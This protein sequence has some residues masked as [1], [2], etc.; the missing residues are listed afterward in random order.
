MHNIF[1]FQDNDSL[2]SWINYLENL[3]TKT[4]NLNLDNVYLVANR[5]QL[6]NPAKFVFIVTGTNGKGTTC[7]VLEKLLINAGYSVGVYNSPH[8]INYTER[9]RIQGQEL[10]DAQHVNSFLNIELNRKNTLLTYFEFST[11]SALHLFK[12]IKLD[13]VILEVGLGG[14]LDA[15]NIIDADI[16]IITNIDLDHTN[17]LGNTRESI[18]REKAGVFRTNKLAIVAEQNMP[19]SISTIAKQKNTKLLKIHQEW[20][21]KT[22]NLNWS[23]YDSYGKLENL[24]LLNIPLVNAASALVALRSA[25]FKISELNIRQNLP[26]ISIP[27]RFQIINQHP[28]IILD[29]AHNPHA[30]NYLAAR[31]ISLRKIGKIHAIVGMLKDK[32]IQGTLCALEMQ[33]DYWYCI[34]LNCP[35]GAKGDQLSTYLV[36]SQVF[37]D[38]K[39]A[40]QT[41]LKK[42]NTQDI[43]LVFGSFYTVAQFIN[44]VKR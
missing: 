39:N 6:L 18:G 42:L 26:C 3:H 24:P 2:K 8:L 41:A 32:D 13:V 22:T 19:N 5:L 33:V 25:K 37:S 15:T 14:R 31:L 27:G 23:L 40:W 4:I 12:I 34:T 35:R 9:V 17:F 28:K 16:A 43:L 21:Y 29:V 10:S 1:N 30:A 7:Y 38:I 11:L 20:N 36:K 44:L